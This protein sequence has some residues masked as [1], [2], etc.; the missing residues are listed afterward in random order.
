MT[1]RAR[2]RFSSNF[3]ALLLALSLHAGATAA[4][5]PGKDE[6]RPGDVAWI[7]R[8]WDTRYVIYIGGDWESRK[9]VAGRSKVSDT[10]FIWE[11]V[12]DSPLSI[13]LPHDQPT[14]TSEKLDVV[15]MEFD[16]NGFV[17]TPHSHSSR[18][19]GRIN[20]IRALVLSEGEEIKSKQFHVASWFT[21]IGDSSTHWA[22]GFC[23]SRDMRHPWAD[24]DEFYPYGRAFVKGEYSTTFGCREWAYQLYDDE[25][26]YIDVTSYVPKTVDSPDGTYIREVLGWARFGDKKP[27]IGKH[28]RTWY[29]LYDCP[30][31]GKPGPIA[32]IKAW[33][34][35]NGWRPPRPPTQSPTFPDP[36]ARSGTYP[37]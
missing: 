23:L 22:P 5:T 28:E 13:P 16:E 6:Y 1:L 20:R 8:P 26:P 17:T 34:V 15:L 21:G 36:P 10:F 9:R 3:A 18:L 7:D 19:R 30:G 25:R 4:G 24:T 14:S 29:C 27:I 33:A 37:K 12:F 2:P 11:G 32:D 35:R 31:G